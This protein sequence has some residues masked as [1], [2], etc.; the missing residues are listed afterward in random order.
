MVRNQAVDSEFY[1]LEML[2]EGP[3]MMVMVLL[4][5]H[6]RAVSFGVQP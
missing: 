3:K 2:Y 5:N 6:M 4:M 1:M